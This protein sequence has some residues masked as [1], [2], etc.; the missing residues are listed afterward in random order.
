[1]SLEPLSQP[2]LSET[3]LDSPL[4]QIDEVFLIV[5]GRNTQSLSV[6]INSR[7]DSCKL[8]WCCWISK[9]A[10]LLLTPTVSFRS[11][12]LLRFWINIGSASRYLLGWLIVAANCT[13]YHWIWSSTSIVGLT[14]LWHRLSLYNLLY[15][16]KR[17]VFLHVCVLHQF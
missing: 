14:C 17:F 2:G 12:S 4:F 15:P 5:K 11:A 3:C 7:L 6:A 8:S 13:T 1:M 10:P 9:A 16:K